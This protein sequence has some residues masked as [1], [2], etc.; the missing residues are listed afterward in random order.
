MTNKRIRQIFTVLKPYVNGELITPV[1]AKYFKELEELVLDLQ[2]EVVGLKEF[3]QKVIDW[4][5]AQ[6]LTDEELND[7]MMM[8]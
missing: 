7:I 6:I 2:K 8:G 5:N 4:E 1:F 3:K